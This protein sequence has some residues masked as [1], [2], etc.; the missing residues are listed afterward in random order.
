MNILFATYPMA[1]HTPGGG[2]IQL[3]S[4]KKYLEDVGA[5]V[6]LFDPWNPKFEEYD[7]V[8]FFSCIAGSQHFCKFIK[9]LN[10]PLVI[11]SSLWITNETKHYY[12]VEEIKNQ[13]TLAD[14]IITNSNLETN[15]LSNLFCLNRDKLFTVYNGVDESFLT[16]AN[17]LVFR[18]FFKIQG[19]FILNV[20]NIEPRKNQYLLVKAI[21]A[22]PDFK[23]ILIGH[24]RDQAY[25]NS[26]INISNNQVNFIG[27]IEHNLALLKSAYAACDLFVLPSTLETPGLSALEA[28]SQGA[29]IVITE[30]GS[31]KEYFK[32]DVVYINAKSEKSIEQG[33]SFALNNNFNN[34][35]KHFTWKSNLKKLLNVYEYLIDCDAN[36]LCP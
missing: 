28:Y 15:E 18:N 25:F 26:I 19:K 29:K 1:F 22:F 24:I 10:L 34:E 6:T 8:H 36:R 31:T 9:N 21:K 13:L 17:P 5:K 23:L 35:K 33:I 2:E 27:P 14:A 30:E 7:I 4:Y 16:R 12:P 3:L 32:D 20:A 11:S